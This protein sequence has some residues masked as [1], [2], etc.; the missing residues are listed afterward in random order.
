MEEKRWGN[1]S[2]E[3]DEE[4]KK[5]GALSHFLFSLSEHSL[6]QKRGFFF[7]LDTTGV[8]PFQS[9]RFDLLVLALFLSLL[10]RSEGGKA[11]R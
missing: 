4:S 7:P 1:G 6:S 11:R 10:R 2:G 9:V 8:D 5:F 3:R